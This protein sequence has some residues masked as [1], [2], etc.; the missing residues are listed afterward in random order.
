MGTLLTVLTKGGR[1]VVSTGWSEPGQG[2]VDHFTGP[3]VSHGIVLSGFAR[4]WPVGSP[5][6]SGCGVKTQLRPRSY[7]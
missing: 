3:D 7:L 1:A 5:C 2:V 4:M 6:F